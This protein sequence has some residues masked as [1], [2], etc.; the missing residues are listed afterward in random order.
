MIRGT[1]QQTFLFN[2]PSLASCDRKCSPDVTP[3]NLGEIFKED[4]GVEIDIEQAMHW[5]SVA[6]ELGHPKAEKK[7]KK[8]GDC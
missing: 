1:L 3:Y 5:Y 2:S 4:L 8:I 6:L 7:L